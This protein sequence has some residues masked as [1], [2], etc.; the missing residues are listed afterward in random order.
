MIRLLKTPFG[1]CG[2]VFD[3]DII[4]EIILPAPDKRK[5]LERLRHHGS[6]TPNAKFRP[7][8]HVTEVLNNLKRYFNGEKVDFNTPARYI[9]TLIWSSK[10]ERSV[11]KTLMAIPYGRVQ[12]Y[13]WVAQKAG[14]PKASRAVGNALAKNPL[15]IIIPCHRVIKSDGSLGGFSAIG[16]TTLKEKLLKLEKAL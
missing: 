11:Y 1:W 7:G 5:I 15:P 13:Q 10:F 8:H 2:I 4:R 14:R 3:A 16:G 9:T 12:S 6:K